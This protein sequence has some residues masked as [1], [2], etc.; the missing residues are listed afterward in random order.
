MAENSSAQEIVALLHEI[1]ELQRRETALR[2]EY[3]KIAEESA[4]KTVDESKE[5]MTEIRKESDQR[6]K[7]QLEFREQVLKE[8]TKHTELLTRILTRISPIAETDT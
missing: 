2:E 6:L 8:L 3:L 5:R 7:E 4:K 1:A